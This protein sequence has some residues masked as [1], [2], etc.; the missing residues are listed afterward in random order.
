MF[1][2][3]QWQARCQRFVRLL[4]LPGGRFSGLP[5]GEKGSDRLRQGKNFSGLFSVCFFVV[6]YFQQ[7]R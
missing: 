1:Q 5:G 4:G 7:H 2:S 6:I 3:A